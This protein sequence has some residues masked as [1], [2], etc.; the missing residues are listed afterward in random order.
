MKLLLSKTLWGVN[1]QDE[2]LWG[3]HFARIKSEGYSA[4]ESI[5]LTWQGNPKLFKSLLLRHG[6]DLIVQIHTNGGYLTASGYVYC[7]SC[8]FTDHIHSFRSQLVDA[9]EMGA[10]M[11]NTHSGHDSWSNSTAVAYFKDVLA[12]ED[13]VLNNPDRDWGNIVVVHETHRQRLM[14]SPYQTK[15][16]LSHPD[17]ARLK[18]N[19]DLS[20]WVCVCE[21]VF[22]EKDPRDAWWT[23]VLDLV[24]RHCHFIHARIG[25]AEGPQVFDPRDRE[26]W[27]VET[28]SHLDWWTHIWGA[29]QARGMAHS[30]VEPEH[31]ES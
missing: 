8:E 21:H 18:V 20:H 2:S 23:E 15:E 29:Q 6:L 1:F 16:I 7:A 10:A 24:A 17:L 28:N 13:E 5:P 30:C 31:G 3:D 27:C 12:I 11:V 19:A 26:R 22:D 25:H 9:C 14:F 4:V